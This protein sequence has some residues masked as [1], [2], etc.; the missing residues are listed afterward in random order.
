MHFEPKQGQGNP[1]SANIVPCQKLIQ[2]EAARLAQKTE[3]ESF[4]R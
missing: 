1:V 4:W 3:K 2:G